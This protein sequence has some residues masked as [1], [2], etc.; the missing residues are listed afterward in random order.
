MLD[1]DSTDFNIIT[2]VTELDGKRTS[3]SA[4]V[5]V[6]PNMID[7]SS[8]WGK[9][10]NIGENAVV[11]SVVVGT[12]IVYVLLLVWARRKDKQDKVRVRLIQC[13]SVI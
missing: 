10:A 5:D 13:E 12:L 2:C 7:F 9:F 8:V 1:P 4:S 11:F 3:L 6:A